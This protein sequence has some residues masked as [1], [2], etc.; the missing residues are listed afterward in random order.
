MQQLDTTSIYSRLY[1]NI[2]CGFHQTVMPSGSGITPFQ[3][4]NIIVNFS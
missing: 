4:S 3:K 1:I 2:K